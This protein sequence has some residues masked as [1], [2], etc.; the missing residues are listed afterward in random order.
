MMEFYIHSE[1]LRYLAMFPLIKECDLISPVP[2]TKGTTG[3]GEGFVYGKKIQNDRHFFYRF[4][5]KEI[6]RNGLVYVTSEDGY[7]SRQ[8]GERQQLIILWDE[9]NAGFRVLVDYSLSHG[10][11]SEYRRLSKEMNAEEAVISIGKKIEYD[12][13]IGDEMLRLLDS[14]VDLF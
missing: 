4:A 11:M 12:K 3:Y 6:P 7:F 8:K 14:G 10:F 9:Q 13:S 5:G 2:S 1:F